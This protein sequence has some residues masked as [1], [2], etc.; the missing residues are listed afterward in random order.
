M[1]FPY[2]SRLW[3]CCELATKRIKLPHDNDLHAFAFITSTAAANESQVVESGHLVFDGCCGV[4][5]FGWIV[6]VISRHDRHQRAIRYVAQG[7]HLMTQGESIF[8]EVCLSWSCTTESRIFRFEN[9]R[10]M[11]IEITFKA[12]GKLIF[13]H[14]DHTKPPDDHNRYC[15]DRSASWELEFT[16]T[17]IKWPLH[18]HISA[19]Q[20]VMPVM[21]LVPAV[22]SAKWWSSIL[23]NTDMLM[24]H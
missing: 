2:F 12:K 14:T 22:L 21:L 13:T 8:G 10:N 1:C 24:F 11:W 18:T 15:S 17:E 19:F 7:N 9:V 4:A 20:S 5:E 16:E 23:F 6:L 3:A